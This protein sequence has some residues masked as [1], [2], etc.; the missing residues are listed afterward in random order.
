MP[1]GGPDGGN[2]GRGGDIKLRGKEELNTLVDFRFRPQY[3]AENGKSGGS[4]RKT[5]H[6]GES[7]TLDVPCGTSV[8]DEQ[9]LEIIADVTHAGQ[10]VTIA[11]GGE[12]GRGNHSFRSS[13]N[14]SPRQF[15]SG[16]EGEFKQLRLQLKV[17]ADVGLLG[18]PNA[19]KSTLLSVVSASKPRIADYP[20]TTLTPNLGVV[21]VDAARSFVMADV[22]GLIEGAA[23]GHGLGTR[24]LKHLSRTALMLHLVEATPADGSNPL[25]NVATIEKELEQY[26]ATLA[27]RPIWTVVTK[28]DT[29]TQSDCENLLSELRALQPVRPVFAIS[30]VSRQGLSELLDAI[31]SHI[32]STSEQDSSN[33]R[34]RIAKDAMDDMFSRHAVGESAVSQEQEEG[35]VEVIYRRD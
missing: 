7:L 10:E 35:E 26:S 12:S 22:P 4:Q 6:S 20:F 31:T 23:T 13:K 14:R 29:V 16:T 30:S 25:S 18:M 21:D 1:K 9:N 33:V 5:G 15:T 32:A 19:G 27:Q 8:V 11:V 3:K 17:V 24:F 34:D 28:C 2:G